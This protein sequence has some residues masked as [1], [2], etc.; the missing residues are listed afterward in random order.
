MVSPSLPS[1]SIL[2]FLISIFST[3]VSSLTCST[4]KLTGTKTY[5]YCLDLPV[6]NSYLHYTHDQKNSTLS[7]VFIASPPSPAGWVSWGI[8]PTGTGMAGAQVIV[9]FKNDTV[10]AIKTLDLKSYSV[11]IPGKLS[12]DVWDM[13]AEEDGGGFMKI[14][15]TVKVPVNVDGVNHVWQ[16]GSAVMAGR[17]GPHEFNPPN[18]N[19]KGRL[20]LNGAE[21][22]DVPVDFAI[23][24]KNIHGLL[25]TVSWGILFP[26]GVIM[27]RYVKTFPSADPAWFYLHV[28]CQ[29]SAY[30]LGVAGWATGIK[31]GS[32]SEGITFSVHRNVG[33]T[34]FCLATIQIFA[35]LLR[36]N[37]DHKYRFYWNIYH[38]SFGYTI[39]ILGILNIFRG[40]EILSPDHKWKS[41][42]IVVIIALAVIALVLEAITWSFV[43][44]GKSKNNNKTYDGQTRNQHLDV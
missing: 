28:G 12:F 34:L 27:A 41:S 20:S 40:L 37:K 16:V 2:F 31:L 33:I 11:I 35:L 14:F 15:A 13:K 8:N 18:L 17:V 3:T 9:A 5:S 7:V 6:L 1:F 25:N 30:V 23:K 19:S 39:I 43:M 4:Q 29:L 32:E 36:P 44:K 26:L 38:H 21:V 42:Y 10:M 24:K 22:S